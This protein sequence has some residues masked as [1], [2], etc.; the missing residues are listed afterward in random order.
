[1]GARYVACYWGRRSAYK[2]LVGG[3]EGKKPFGRPR[4]KCED[5]IEMDLQEMDGGMDM[6]NLAQCRDR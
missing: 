5:N 1:M 2:V 6:T 4:R 3:P